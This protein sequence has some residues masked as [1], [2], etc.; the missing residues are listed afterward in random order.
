MCLLALRHL[1]S[2]Q[3]RTGPSFQAEL[4]LHTAADSLK[5]HREEMHR[6]ENRRPLLPTLPQTMS[7]QSLKVYCY[8]ML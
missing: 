2:L 7:E 1:V 8:D 4:D 3:A 6:Q 5:L